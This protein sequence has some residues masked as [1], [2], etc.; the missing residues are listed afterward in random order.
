MLQN[1]IYRKY[2]E[3]QYNSHPDMGGAAA[4][5]RGGF[6][7]VSLEEALG[8]FRS[9]LAR[10]QIIMRISNYSYTVNDN[11]ADD[12]QKMCQAAILILQGHSSRSEDPADYYRAMERT[13][14]V[15]DEL[16]EKM[17]ADSRNGH[18]LFNYSINTVAN[19][20]V[21][22]RENYG[23]GKCGWLLVFRFN[24]HFRNCVQSEDAPAWTDGGLTPKDL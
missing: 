19:V 11:T 2:F 18:P 1:D 3:H 23:D 20:N 24:N 22:P 21:S 5:V 8:E 15:T 16:I 14:K 17:I 4:D 6:Q 7:V 13:E 10:D 12:A 9:D